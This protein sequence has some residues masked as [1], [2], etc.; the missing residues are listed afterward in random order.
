MVDP[1]GGPP[2]TN[3]IT[4]GA[5]AAVGPFPMTVRYD[6]PFEGFYQMIRASS[7]EMT[8]FL[9][10]PGRKR[11]LMNR[12]IH[13][14]TLIGDAG[15]SGVIPETIFVPAVQVVLARFRDLSGSQQTVEYGL[16][17]IKYYPMQA[18]QEVRKE[19]FS[20]LERRERTY[21]YWLTSDEDIVL[22]P[23]QT[24][25]FATF[26]V[27][28]DTD[29]EIFKCTAWTDQ[30][31]SVGKTI[32]GQIFESQDGR[33]LSNSMMDISL[34]MGGLDATALAGQFLN[35]GGIFPKRYATSWLVRRGTKFSV[36]LD[37]SSTATVRV[38]LTFW[39]RK[40]SYS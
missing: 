28:G 33:P 14:G 34:L 11:F 18:P 8:L 40:I 22:T 7:Q 15:R 16:S 23:L 36:K 13:L 25:V 20:Y 12:E 19:M 26:T 24:G 17:G 5:G 4:V 30:A 10:L 29:L 2:A 31:G 21:P 32:R 27:P 6:G 9:E 3:V 35:S 1:T 37:S 38:F 39:G